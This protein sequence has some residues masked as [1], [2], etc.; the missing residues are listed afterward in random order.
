[1]GC[2]GDGHCSGQGHETTVRVMGGLLS[3]YDLMQDELF[4]ERAVSC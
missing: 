2:R 4:L 1:M 3:T